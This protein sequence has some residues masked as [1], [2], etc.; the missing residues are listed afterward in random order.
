MGG[1]AAI[2]GVPEISRVNSTWIIDDCA[3]HC[4]ETVIEAAAIGLK[5]D[6]L[7]EFVDAGDLCA[8]DAQRIVDG[9]PM[10]LGNMRDGDCTSGGPGLHRIR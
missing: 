7:A 1:G 3:R 5:S 10:T 9:E 8:L 2:I 6:D 4:E